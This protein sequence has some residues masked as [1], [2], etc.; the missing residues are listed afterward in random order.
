MLNTMLS[1]S[2]A[3]L[4]AALWLVSFQRP[5]L[6]SGSDWPDWRGP[7]RDGVSPEKG[8]PEKW[9]PQGE[10]LVRK[11]PYGGRS[12]PIVMGARVFLFNSAGGLSD[13]ART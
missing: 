3:L 12:A 1:K 6:N 11:A 2:L 8:L 13:G 9:S 5:P 7:G 10:N 4:L